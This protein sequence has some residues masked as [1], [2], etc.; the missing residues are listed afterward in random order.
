MNKKECYECNKEHESISFCR[1][2]G[3][4]LYEHSVQ[5]KDEKYPLFKCE[6]CGTINFWD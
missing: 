5:I 2:C 3:S 4:C 6:I 1:E